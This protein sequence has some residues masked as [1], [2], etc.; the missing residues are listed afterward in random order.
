MN[1]KNVIKPFLLL[2]L[3]YVTVDQVKVIHNVNI[4]PMYRIE[5]I[6]LFSCVRT[7]AS[8]LRGFQI[9]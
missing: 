3:C 7:Y 1:V 8:N 9:F 4:P 6:D 5:I 2:S